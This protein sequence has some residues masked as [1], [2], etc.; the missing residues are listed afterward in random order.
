MLDSKA[1]QSHSSISKRKPE[2]TVGSIITR[3]IDMEQDPNAAYI[4]V[5]MILKRLIPQA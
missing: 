1:G 3:N 5:P 2:T 4:I